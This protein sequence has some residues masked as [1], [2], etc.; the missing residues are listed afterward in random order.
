MTEAAYERPWGLE[1]DVVIDSLRNEM[2][3]QANDFCYCYEFFGIFGI[4]RP[5]NND[6]VTSKTSKKQRSILTSITEAEYIV[7]C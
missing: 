6:R 7:L 5:R 4:L 3:E 2:R 1:Y